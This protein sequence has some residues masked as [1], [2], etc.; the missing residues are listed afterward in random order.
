MDFGQYMDVFVA[1]CRELLE[2]LNLSILQL[3]RVPGDEA[4]IDEIFRVAHSLKGVSSTMGFDQ[5]AGLTH[6][7]EYLL[8]LV[9]SGD[10]AADQSLITVLLRCLDLSEQAVDGIEANG[11]EDIDP[12]ALIVEL[13]ALIQSASSTGEPT[14]AVAELVDAGADGATG[15][16][17]DPATLPAGLDLLRVR[18]DIAAS[19]ESVS[20]RAFMAY[21]AIESASEPVWS[22]PSPED[23][24]DWENRWVDVLVARDSETLAAE[25]TEALSR[26]PELASVTITAFGTEAAAAGTVMPSTD[27]DAAATDM[28]RASADTSVADL[29][30]TSP[31]AEQVAAAVVPDSGATSS[32]PA[33]GAVKQRRS[34]TI[35]VDAARLDALM[36]LMGEVVVHRSVVETSIRDRDLDAAGLAVQELRRA[37]QALQAEVM[38]VRM[39]PVE[40]ALMRMP[41]L[42]RDLAA[43]LDKEVELVV[44]GADTEIDRSV[45]DA[46]GDPL[47]HLVRNGLDHGIET[48]EARVAAGK[49]RAATLTISAMHAGGNVIVS[50]ADDG[51]GIDPIKVKARAVE[52]GIITAEDALVMD[53]QSAV[54]LVFHA[55]FS[56]AEVATDVSGRGVGMDAV[57]AMCREWGGDIEIES[58]VGRGSVARIRIPLTLAVMTVLI[59]KAGVTNVAIPIDRIERTVRLVDHARVDMGGGQHM[60]RLD[61]GVLSEVDLGGAVGYGAN[62]A[63]STFGVIVR[64]A[65]GRRVVLGVSEL[66][67]EHEAVTKPLPKALGAED[68]F[69]GAAVQGDGSVVLIVD[70]DHL[71]EDGG[72]APAGA[73]SFEGNVR[74][75]ATHA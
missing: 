43:K 47:V 62:V 60:V 26:I 2:S 50:V 70:C 31:V 27:T 36:H 35:R 40:S 7:M 73:A 71:V 5:M 58:W 41:R 52:R 3:E 72:R 45:V 64:G 33:A 13:Q 55:G 75:G 11:V 69:M 9:R 51:A 54:E 63:G 65:A 32:S 34:G 1:E 25:L 14:A 12:S 19:C 67:G 37:T 20:I 57:R 28:T 6:E 24:D 17:P 22:E 56:T 68:A 38:N 53:D 44:E 18:V 61:D 10:I 42:V 23:L 29:R 46:L 30:P 74:E 49:P 48:P 16:L 21:S 8:D 4:M 39:V 15:N 66:I 59:V